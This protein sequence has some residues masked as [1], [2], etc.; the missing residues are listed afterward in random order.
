VAPSFHSPICSDFEQ[1]ILF[2]TTTREVYDSTLSTGSLWLR[3]D[4]YYRELEDETRRDLSEGGNYSRT[5]L[6]L[7]LQDNG[8]NLTISG[9]GEI[10]EEL[11]PHYIVSL[12]G[13]S[14]SGEQRDLLGGCTFGIKNIVRLAA[15]IVYRASS[16]LNCSGYRYGPIQYQYGNLGRT[17]RVAGVPLGLSNDSG[18][19]GLINPEFLRKLPIMPFIEQDEWRIIVLTDGYLDDAGKAPL[20]LNLETS[21]FYPYCSA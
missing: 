21:H 5:I 14:I 18:S 8:P 4:R 17:R 11:P 12:H 13:P 10:G 20:E 16:L 19:L 2:R 6:P 9:D 15:E 1:P 7:R 3:S